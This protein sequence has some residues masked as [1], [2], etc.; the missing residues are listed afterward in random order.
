MLAWIQSVLRGY[1]T[2]FFI[3]GVWSGAVIVGL[4]FLRPS[5]AIMGIVAVAVAY[6]TAVFIGQ[7]EIFFKSHACIY[8]PLLV[9]LSIGAHTKPTPTLLLWTVLAGILTEFVVVLITHLLWTRH[10]FPILSLPFVMVST[11]V[12]IANPT[13]FLAKTS[14][15][16]ESC[17]WLIGFL[18][19]LGSLIF[20]PYPIVGAVLAGAILI[21]SRIL[22]GLALF[23]YSVGSLVQGWLHGSMMPVFSDPNSFNFILVAMAIGGVFYAPSLRQSCYTGLAVAFTPLLV[24]ACLAFWTPYHVPIFTTPFIG[25]TLSFLCLSRILS[26]T[27]PSFVYQNIPEDKVEYAFVQEKRFPKK[28]AL[29]LPFLGTRTI[30]KAKNGYQF[31]KTLSVTHCSSDS[32]LYLQIEEDHVFQNY[33]EGSTVYSYGIPQDGACISSILQNTYYSQATSFVVGSNYVFAINHKG[34]EKAQLHLQVGQLLDGTFYLASQTGTMYMGAWHGFWYVYNL[35]GNDP[36]LCMMAQACAKISLYYDT[37]LSWTHAVMTQHLP[38]SWKKYLTRFLWLLIPEMC[39]PVAHYHFVS[40]TT[41]H[42][43]IKNRLF[44]IVSKTSI[45][46]D[47]KLQF[48]QIEVGDFCFK[49]VD[50]L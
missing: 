19:S 26:S 47:S 2:L 36:W 5:M 33:Q 11:L 45:T 18:K 40:P 28:R 43:C 15:I 48:L 29:H 39:M 35:E 14:S 1:S 17:S 37:H 34:K 7:K 12:H 50:H 42:G 44:T 41:I 21:Q 4:S 25:V 49:R 32:C 31:F 10:S 13:L 24:A 8:N 30:F 23:G 22:L 9:G 46:L 6:I 20:L 27:Q 38:N 3:E 16:P